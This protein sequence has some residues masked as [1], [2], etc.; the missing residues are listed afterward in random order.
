MID[1]AWSQP[2]LPANDVV[3]ARVNRQVKE[4]ASAI[5]AA[6]GLTPSDAFRM[7]LMRIVQER[8]L[9]FE[10]LIPNE[11]TIAAMREAQR[12]DLPSAPD[13]TSLLG[14]VHADD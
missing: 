3:R 11:V 5:L 6:I 2:P 14:L 12:A 13:A 8:T 4:E 9:P 7:L 10:P 1:S